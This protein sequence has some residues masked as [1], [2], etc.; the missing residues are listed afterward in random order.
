MRDDKTE[1]PLLTLR[2]A[3]L[4]ALVHGDYSTHTETIPI[5]VIMCKDRLEMG[6]IR[7]TE[8]MP[9]DVMVTELALTKNIIEPTTKTKQ[10]TTGISTFLILSKAEIYFLPEIFLPKM[11]GNEK[12]QREQPMH[13]GTWI[14]PG[15]RE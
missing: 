5:K 9:K 2:E 6:N 13:S 1:Y 15:K 4:N 14:E 3:V 11:N 12:W 10:T 8:Y 7:F